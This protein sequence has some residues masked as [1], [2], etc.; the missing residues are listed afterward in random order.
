MFFI[1]FVFTIDLSL[2]MLS[3]CAGNTTFACRNATA[4]VSTSCFAEAWNKNGGL[5]SI[6]CFA[7]ILGCIMRG[8]LVTKGGINVVGW[9]WSLKIKCVIYN[10][11][12]VVLKNNFQAEMEMTT[13]P[14][15]LL[16]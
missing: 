3:P 12:L 5:V 1:C 4:C 8:A 9:D 11:S 6:T 10:S 7:I 13:L 2:H 16:Y 14:R 15:K